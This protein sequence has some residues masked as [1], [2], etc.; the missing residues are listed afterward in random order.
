MYLSF[1]IYR[2]YRGFFVIIPE[3]FR[4]VYR[5]LEN[6]IDTPFIEDNEDNLRIMET[7][8]NNKPI[9]LRT[10][11]TVSVLASIV[12]ASYVVSGAFRVLFKFYKSITRRSNGSNISSKVSNSFSVAA[13]EVIRNE[14]KILKFAHHQEQKR[15]MNSNDINGDT[16]TDIGPSN[17]AP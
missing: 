9:R 16:G 5:K 12:T 8:D 17:L 15:T 1:C 4:E 2:A 10:A 3:V 6:S 7:S 14:D 13:D 11:I